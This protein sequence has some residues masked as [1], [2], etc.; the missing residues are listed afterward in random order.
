MAS[1][2]EV[3]LQQLR[4]GQYFYEKFTAD[5]SDPE[6]FKPPAE[7]ANHAAWLLGHVACSEDSLAAQITGGAK[8]IPEATHELFKSGSTCVANPSKYPSRRQI[9]ELFRNSRANTIEALTKYDDRKWEE[10]SPQGWDKSVFPTMGA[11]WALQGT[12]QFWHIGQLAVCRQAMK[13][14]PA[15]S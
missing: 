9:D 2:K 5:L 11:M 8:R 3:V 1:A 15:L 10:P 7:G 13:K 12:H 4:S 6:Y 14:K